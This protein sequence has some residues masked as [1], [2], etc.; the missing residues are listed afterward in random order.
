MLKQIVIKIDQ[1]ITKN[2]LLKI[3]GFLLILFLLRM[4]QNYWGNWMTLFQSIVQPFVYGFIIAY[5]FHPF[6]VM[7]KKHK[8]PQNVSILLILIFII[9]LIFI[10]II[11]LIPTLYGRLHDLVFNLSE[12]VE[13]ISERIKVIG[14]FENFSLIDSLTNNLTKL[15]KG[16]EDWLPQVVSSIPGLMN[17]ILNVFTNSLFSIIVAIY[18]LA[19][20]ERV[21][22]TISKFIAMLF[23]NSEVYVHRMNQN[24]SVYLRSLL[25][26]MLIKFVEYSLFY[27]LVGHP[28]YLIIGLLTSFGAIIPYIGGTIANSIGIITALTLSPSKIVILIIGILILSNVDA[29]VISPLVHEKRSSLGPLLTLFAVFAGGVFMGPIG[30]MASIPLAIM[31]KSGFEM[32]HE[33]HPEINR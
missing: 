14:N 11:M 19:D 4:T 32:Y 26:I 27:F 1:K 20:F 16:Y 12:S 23:K 7:M 2:I 25:I 24:V 5:I 9:I 8:I 29:Y 18:M 28:D 22:K 3:I 33:Q 21:K 15:L 13:W 17:T 10:L 30:I 31:I 6:V